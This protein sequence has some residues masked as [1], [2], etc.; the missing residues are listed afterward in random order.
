MRSSAG[1]EVLIKRWQS[2][3]HNWQER[4]D[5]SD[6]GGAAEVLGGH[7]LSVELGV[8][9]QL[10]AVAQVVEGRTGGHLDG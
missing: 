9:L 6:D 3:R 7:H 5:G 8:P 2:Q 10:H 1:C 4:T